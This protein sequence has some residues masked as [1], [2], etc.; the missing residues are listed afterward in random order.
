M[1]GSL[2]TFLLAV[3]IGAAALAAGYGAALWWRPT[4]PAPD[5]TQTAPAD[6]ALPD[7]TGRERRLSE[8][9]GRPIVINFWATWCAPCREEIPLLTQARARHAAKG[10]EVI[11]VA[12]DKPD[13]AAEFAAKLGVS[14]PVLIANADTLDLMNRYGNPIGSLPYT[15]IL[16]RAGNVVHRKLGAYRPAELEQALLATG[17]LTP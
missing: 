17:I 10:L 16:D 4:P 6:F 2:R 1:A 9:R 13:A 15:V 3:V 12:L 7:L 8:W 14:Y 5:T 11:G